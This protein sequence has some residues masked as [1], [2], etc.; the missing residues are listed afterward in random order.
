MSKKGI[1]EHE[2]KLEKIAIDSNVFRNLNFINYLRINKEEIQVYLP[3]I[4]SFEIGYYFLTKGITWEDFLKEIAKFNGIFLE[5]DSVVLLEVLKNALNNKATLPFRHHFRDFMIGTQCE[6]TSLNLISNN[7]N[8]FTWLK[9]I[10]I[11]TPEEFVL[12]RIKK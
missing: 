5:W 11:Q 3:S 6:N 8:H 4:V 10:S 9:R 12:E 1:G 2:E 7:K